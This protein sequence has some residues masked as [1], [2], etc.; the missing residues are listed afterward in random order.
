MHSLKKAV[1]KETVIQK[2]RTQVFMDGKSEISVDTVNEFKGDFCRAFNTV[3][4]TAGRENL[5]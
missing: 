1:K 4:V 2:E 5:E 3:F